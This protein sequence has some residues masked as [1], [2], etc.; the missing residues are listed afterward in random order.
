MIKAQ[1][2]L[3]TVSLQVEAEDIKDVFRQTELIS[4]CPRTC[5]C[6]SAQIAPAYSKSQEGFEF[7]YLKCSD[8]GNEFKFG[9][10][11]SDQALF[12]KADDGWV[13]PFRQGGS[14]RNN[15]PEGGEDYDV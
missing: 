14:A 8:C 11:R 12:P 1:L 2:K 10:R 3:G 6:G 15:E 5:S 7:F 4:Q 9:Q 13:K